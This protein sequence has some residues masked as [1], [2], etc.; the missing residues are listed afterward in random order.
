V[1]LVVPSDR[2]ETTLGHN[3]GQEPRDTVRFDLELPRDAVVPVGTTVSAEWWVRG[4]LTR[5]AQTCGAVESAL[6]LTLEHASTRVQFGRPLGRFQAVQHLIAEAAGEAT[7]A[8]A[9]C[10]AA[11]RT[12][13]S[14]GVGSPAAELAAGI[15][16]CQAAR[17]ATVVSRVSHQVHGAIGFTLDHRLRHFTLRMQ[18]WRAEFGDERSWEHRIGVLVAGAPDL[19]DVV[20]SGDPERI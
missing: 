3:L 1:V 13:S 18:A 15:A 16:K 5:S 20:T 2:L 8:R 4:A 7:M 9:A 17:A 12:I 14:C 6:R 19:W 11:V 10:D